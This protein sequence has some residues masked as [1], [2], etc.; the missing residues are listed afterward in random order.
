MLDRLKGRW[1][2]REMKHKRQIAKMA[3]ERISATTQ[4]I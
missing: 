2:L 1:R 3:A 4:Q